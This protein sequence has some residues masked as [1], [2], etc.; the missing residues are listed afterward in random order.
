[1]I[2]AGKQ[3]K[4][5]GFIEDAEYHGR[6]AGPGSKY[7]LNYKIVDDEPRAAG[8]WKEGEHE[9]TKAGRLL[10]VKKLR[11]PAPGDYKVEDAFKATI[12]TE[13]STKFPVAAL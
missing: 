7:E 4:L 6:N 3:I 8:I 10:P 1:M 11:G 13:R 9:R 5:C 2:G 12:P